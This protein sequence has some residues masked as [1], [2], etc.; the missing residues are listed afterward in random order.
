M[1][2][3]SKLVKAYGVYNFQ[4]RLQ[5]LFVLRTTRTC[6]GFPL[7]QQIQMVGMCFYLTQ[8]FLMF[9]VSFSKSK[10]LEVHASSTNTAIV[11]FVFPFLSLL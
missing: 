1:L 8:R 10:Y 4:S 2:G 7:C 3:C 6:S 9:S 11:P 5:S